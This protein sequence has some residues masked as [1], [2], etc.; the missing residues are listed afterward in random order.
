M[1]L[2]NWGVG[3]EEGVKCVEMFM[4]LH[5]DF[6][7]SAGIP[8][9]LS[10][11]SSSR[12]EVS[13]SSAEVNQL[14]IYDPSVLLQSTEKGGRSSRARQWRSS[15]YALWETSLSSSTADT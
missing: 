11:Q 5:I 6:T 2:R 9:G 8:F 10:A 12:R 4:K 15:F 7:L 3:R 14:I 1:P 13:L